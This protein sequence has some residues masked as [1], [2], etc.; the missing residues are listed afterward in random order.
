MK[1][2][3]ASISPEAGFL[4]HGLRRKKVTWRYDVQ[5]SN[6]FLTYIFAGFAP[7]FAKNN[8]LTQSN[9]LPLN[10][11]LPSKDISA[12]SDLALKKKEMA[13]EMLPEERKLGE[14]ED[15]NWVG[16]AKDLQIGPDIR[17][18]VK[19]KNPDFLKR[20]VWGPLTMAEFREVKHRLKEL[21]KRQSDTD[22]NIVKGKIMDEEEL[23]DENKMIDEKEL[24]EPKSKNEQNPKEK[25]ENIGSIIDISV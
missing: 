18:A 24:I 4:L 12:A 10:N 25:G 3:P 15:K 7:S 23:I 17:F 22:V 6:N 16:E 9:D 11:E 8:E 20:I 14:F 19:S 5:I 21:E 1:N 13:T 2:K